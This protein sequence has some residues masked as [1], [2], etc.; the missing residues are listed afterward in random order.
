M[1]TDLFRIETDKI[2]LSLRLPKELGSETDLVRPE[3]RLA[4]LSVNRGVKHLKIHRS[5]LPPEIANDLQIQVGPR[6]YEET[7]Y[8]V[9]LYSTN[10]R[11]VEL[12][13]GDPKILNELHADADGTI[14]HGTI[15]FRSQIGCSRFTAYVGGKA[16]F[17][18]E[19][20]VFP[21]KLDYAADY[22]LI[23]ADIQEIMAG[24]VL[25]YLRS[26]FKLGFAIESEN[27][28]RLEWILL[29]R[30][31]MNDLERALHYIESH[32]HPGL[33][34]EPLPTRVEKLRHPDATTSRM[35]VRGKGHGPK[36]KKA[37]GVELRSRIAERRPSLT[38]DTPEHRWLASQLHQIRQTL[39]EIHQAERKHGRL[40]DARGRRIAEEI[41]LLERRVVALQRLPFIS[42]AKGPAPAELNSLKL[43][44]QAGYREARRACLILLQGLRV[45]GGPI[46][47]SVKEIH[48][49]YEYWCYLSLVQI[50][51]RL[52][53]QK[54]PVREVFSIN[55]NGL[56]VSLQRGT[57]Q[58]I[59]FLDGDRR[60]ELAF[61]P[62]YKG[63]AFIRPQNPDVVLTFSTP[64][65]PV[66]RLVFDA[67]YQ[68]NTAPA[69]VNAYGT[70]GPPQ[71]AINALHRY[72][73]AILEETGLRGPRSETFKRSVIEAVALFPYADIENRFRDGLLWSALERVGIGAIPFLPRETR[74]LEEWLQAV[75][76][77]GGWATAASAIPD[78]SLEVLRTWQEA[79]K[80]TVFIG[81]LRRKA[82]Q[83]LDWIKS[84]RCYYAP[85]ITRQ[86]RQFAVRWLAIYAPRSIRKPGALTHWA[87]VKK[88][89]YK[90]RRDIETPWL[91]R[92]SPSEKQ[93]VYELGEIQELKRPIE[94]RGSRGPGKAHAGNRWTTLLGLERASE[95][96]ELS[97]ET[98]MEWRLYDDLRT[99][100]V[101]F[102]LEP[103]ALKGLD[104]NPR[105]GRTWFVIDQLR[106]LYKGAAGFLIRK[107]GRPDNYQSDLAR[108]VERLVSHTKT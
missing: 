38:Q 35:I 80:E 97:L 7:Q 104:Q 47:L 91:P 44:A 57:A 14:L 108:V 74:Y 28:S 17:E 95:F 103:A 81:T 33:V 62:Q 54:I 34:R 39:R 1:N 27:P 18:F 31:V 42:E 88:F 53:G 25:E 9:L 79:E 12:R 55:Q 58:T 15:T 89:A 13:H 85:L 59:K 61:N 90:D 107:K 82:R 49:L 60:L 102:S 87:P 8:K 26:T 21:S 71:R 67:K 78:Q 6:L 98:C 16:E 37:L 105:R 70:P 64:G 30:H 86:S 36:S 11:P 23:L 63:A 46:G 73:D 72:R 32:P 43:P 66:M 10:K 3:G 69:Y 24:L 48:C 65:W 93:I 76:N 19:V 56:H 41:S 29:L 4:I 101:D 96:R 40:N 94:N 2:Q 84:R 68:V 22:D 75:L 106:V 20:E 50:V 100:K 99:R 51:A 52:I 77:R 83:H 5:N 92:G 45:D